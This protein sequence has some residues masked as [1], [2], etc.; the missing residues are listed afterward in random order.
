[1]QDIREE[2]R[3][4]I[5]ELFMLKGVSRRAPAASENMEDFRG[6]F[7][8]ITRRGQNLQKNL[9]LGDKHPPIRKTHSLL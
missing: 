3:R 9:W 5:K 2:R 6:M 7:S 8:G 1:M 4:Q